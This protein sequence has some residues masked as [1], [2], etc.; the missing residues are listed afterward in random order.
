[1]GGPGY[2]ARIQSE[3]GSDGRFRKIREDGGV[4]SLREPPSPYRAN[5]RPEMAVLRGEN[6][7]FW[8]LSD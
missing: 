4:F 8:K 1:M 2:V 7:F 5:S 6:S 3:L